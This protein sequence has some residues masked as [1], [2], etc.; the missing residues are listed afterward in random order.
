LPYIDGVDTVDSA[1][2]EAQPLDQESGR[3]H[4]RSQLRLHLADAPSDYLVGALEN[5][6]LGIEE[7]GTLL[8]NRGGTAD[9][10]SRVGRN[11]SWMRARS[12][13]VAVVTH[14]KAP[15]ILA[16]RYLPHLAWRDLADVSGNLALSPVLRREAEKLIK[17]RAP[18]L[19]LGEKISLARRGS[20][21]IVEF[22]L[23]ETDAMVLRALAGNARATEADLLSILARR[24]LPAGFL[25]WLADQSSWSRRRTVRVALIRHPQTPPSSSLKLIR[26]LS[27]RDVL[28]LHRDVMAPRLVRVAAERLLA[29]S[30]ALRASSRPQF[31]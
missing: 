14:P 11:R 12:I 24:D 9:I 27:R 18:E 6:E 4:A 21:G 5:P 25:S 8:R 3:T 17:T 7:L 23:P 28:E 16:R 22:L 13:Q 10:V 19:S 29:G 15:Q 31:G 20:R 30:E 2:N 1:P 26:G